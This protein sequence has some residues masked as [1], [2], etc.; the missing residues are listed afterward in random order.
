MG[1]ETT[2]PLESVS[3]HI[4][5]KKSNKLTLISEVE[6]SSTSTSS[7]VIKDGKRRKR[8]T[9]FISLNKQDS[10]RK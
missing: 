10:T 5:V 4:Y 6:T 9:N 1:A 3:Q 8:L 2:S 7:R